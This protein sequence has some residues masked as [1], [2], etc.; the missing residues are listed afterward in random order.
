MEVLFDRD[1]NGTRRKGVD[2]DVDEDRI[3]RDCDRGP[4]AL[5]QRRIPRLV[6]LGKDRDLALA[7]R[8]GLIAT[9]RRPSIGSGEIAKKPPAR[10]WGQSPPTRRRLCVAR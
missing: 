10:E 2:D 5:L 1:S 7:S 9:P 4:V 3:P 8:D 6:R